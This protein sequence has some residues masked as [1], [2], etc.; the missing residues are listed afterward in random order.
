MTMIDRVAVLTMKTV[1]GVVMTMTSVPVVAA[2]SKTVPA[3]VSTTKKS[4]AVAAKAMSARKTRC[5][6]GRELLAR[7]V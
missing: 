4:H 3:A 7:S 6:T 2:A 1:R 5:T